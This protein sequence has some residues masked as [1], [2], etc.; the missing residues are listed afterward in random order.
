MTQQFIEYKEKKYFMIKNDEDSQGYQLGNIGLDSLGDIK[1]LED[2][3]NLEYLDLSYNRLTSLPEYICDFKSLK[4]LYLSANQLTHLPDCIHN[5]KS[6]EF[7]DLRDNKLTLLP[8]SIGK[9]KNLD[10]LLLDG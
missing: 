9:L 2:S 6:L 4:S 5:L 10:S 1:G 3:Q 7:I 8:E